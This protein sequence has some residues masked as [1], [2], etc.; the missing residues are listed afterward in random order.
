MEGVKES[1]QSILPNLLPELLEEVIEQL[2]SL[3]VETID[4]L[5]LVES[6]DLPMLKPI[7]VRKLIAMWTQGTSAIHT[8]LV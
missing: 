1:V 3:G 7:Q 2:A 4:D 6:T 8:V 5:K